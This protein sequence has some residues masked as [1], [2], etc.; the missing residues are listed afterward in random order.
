MEKN[1]FCINAG[2]YS[3]VL[4]F[5]KGSCWDCCLSRPVRDFLERLC[6]WGIKTVSKGMAE[7]LMKT[8][9]ILSM[10]VLV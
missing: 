1:V 10:E 3:P 8:R 5:V 6:E 9:P 7:I 4:K 2:Y